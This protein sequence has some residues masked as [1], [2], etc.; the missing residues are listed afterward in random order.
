VIVAPFL[1]S[2]RSCLLLTHLAASLVRV[3][4]YAPP[5][6][7]ALCLL[8]FPFQLMDEDQVITEGFDGVLCKDLLVPL[9]DPQYRLIASSEDTSAFR[10]LDL[11]FLTV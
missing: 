6:P 7:S 1:L 3:L 9:A 5:S 11:S 2:G 4:L 10:V 8:H